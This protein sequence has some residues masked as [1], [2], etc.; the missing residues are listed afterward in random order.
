MFVATWNTAQ[1]Y[2]ILFYEKDIQQIE[3]V[4]RRAARFVQKDY[5]RT[6]SVSSML[7]DL[8]WHSLQSRRKAARLSLLHKIVSGKLNINHQDYLMPGDTRTRNKNSLKFA[9]I[10][11]ETDAY[12]HSFFV[13]TIPEWNNLPS[14]IVNI[15]NVHDFRTNVHKFLCNY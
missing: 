3:M 15:E 10:L 11:S 7:H 14:D 5:R 4:Q 6:S 9:Q 8:D 13:R 2:G 12:A 1:Q